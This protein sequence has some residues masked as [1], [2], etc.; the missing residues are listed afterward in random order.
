MELKCSI[1]IVSY[2]G[3]KLLEKCLAAIY[4]GTHKYPFEIIV[5]DNHSHDNSVEMIRKNYPE[6][7]LISNDENYFFAKGNNIGFEKSS[8]KYILLLN[9]DTEV[10][11]DTIDEMIEYLELHQNIAGACGQ[12]LNFDNTIQIGFNLKKLPN[13]FLMISEILLLHHFPFIKKYYDSY[14]CRDL[15]YQKPQ[16]VEQPAASCM[17]LRRSVIEKIGLF[18][19]TFYYFYND[20]DLCLKL[21]NG[22]YPL[23]YLPSA[24]IYHHQNASSKLIKSKQWTFHFYSNLLQYVKKHYEMPAVLFMR[25]ILIIS[26]FEKFI[27]L[28]ILFFILKTKFRKSRMFGNLENLKDAFSSSITL[29]KVALNIV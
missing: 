23:M 9:N 22:G 24:K 16:L 13:Y 27:L 25:L 2:N 17:M 1:L 28:C 3:H 29:I 11:S 12:L 8:G 15:D 21:K 10:Q 14:L 7:L 26:T 5:I 18:D 4:S 6:V 20:V 19:E